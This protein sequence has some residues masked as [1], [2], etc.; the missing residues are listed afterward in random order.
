[1]NTFQLIFVSFG[2]VFACDISL[3]PEFYNSCSYDSLLLVN[4]FTSFV[5]T[6]ENCGLEVDKEAFY[7]QPY[8]FYNDAVDDMKYTLIM[9]DNDNP[10]AFD[11]NLY[12]H[13]LVTDIDGNAL[14]HGLGI[15][16]GNTIAGN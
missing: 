13:W 12:L 9:I 6:D 5:I 4:P 3:P 15:E 14:K 1:M 16:P 10:L 11:G 2:L 7:E 8:V